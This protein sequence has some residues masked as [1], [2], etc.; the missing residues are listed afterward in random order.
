MFW[1]AL[2][3]LCGKAFEGTLARAPE[4]DTTFA[5]Q[6]LVMHVRSCTADRIRIPFFVGDDRSRTWILTRRDGRIELRHDHR[7][8]DGTEDA[9]TGYGGT[10][11]NAGSA[12]AQFFPADEATRAMIPEAFSN[13]WM[14]RIVPGETLSYGLWRL[15]TPRIFQVDFDVSR[16]V[17][18]PPAPWGW[19]D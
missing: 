3:G 1:A 6:R 13:V 17:T 14:F 15:G 16:E 10:T 8:D 12:A 2:T 9:V 7:H 5:D 19:Q 11:T 4:G 18:P